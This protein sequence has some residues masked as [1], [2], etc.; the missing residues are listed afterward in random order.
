MKSMRKAAANAAKECDDMG[1]HSQD[2]ALTSC[3]ERETGCLVQSL[4]VLDN[5]G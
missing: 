1:C 5:V 3:F 4:L 2:A